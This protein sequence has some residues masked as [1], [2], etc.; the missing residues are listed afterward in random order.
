M[1]LIVAS[2][3]VFLCGCIYT[4]D[5][6]IK[7]GGKK[8]TERDRCLIDSTE[9]ISFSKLADKQRQKARKKVNK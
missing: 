6:K 2:R 9:I 5:R 3:F 1:Q 7:E 8:T 4:G